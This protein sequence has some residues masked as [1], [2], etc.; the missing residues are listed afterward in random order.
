MSVLQQ[1]SA[2]FG[3]VQ[4]EGSAALIKQYR[5]DHVKLAVWIIEEELKAA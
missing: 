4:A 3:L 2:T 5:P 1:D